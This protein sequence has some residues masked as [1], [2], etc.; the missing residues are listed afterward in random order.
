MYEE[1]WMPKKQLKFELK[2]E[3]KILKDDQTASDI[4]I[5]SSSIIY[6]TEI[7]EEEAKMDEDKK[8]PSESE[9]EQVIC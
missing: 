6:L 5:A 2:F 7:K 3:N 8:E 1:P 9:V 4:G